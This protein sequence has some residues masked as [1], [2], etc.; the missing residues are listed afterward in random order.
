[1]D[2][3]AEPSPAEWTQSNQCIQA[4]AWLVGGGCRTAMRS[5]TLLIS[6][7]NRVALAPLLEEVSKLPFWPLREQR[8]RN[9]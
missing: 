4:E 7:E 3:R 5:F 1:M 8:I 9:Q 6:P 2:S